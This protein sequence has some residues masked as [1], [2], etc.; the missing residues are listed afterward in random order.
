MACERVASDLGVRDDV[1][2]CRSPSDEALHGL[3]GRA[4]VVLYT[5]HDEHFGLVPVEAITAGRPVV[6]CASGGP[7][8][9]MGGE[10][11]GLDRLPDWLATLHQGL[12]MLHAANVVRAGLTD[13]LV[14]DVGRSF[15]VLSVWAAVSAMASSRDRRLRAG[16]RPNSGAGRPREPYWPSHSALRGTSATKICSMS[17]APP[18]VLPR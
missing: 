13:G 14:A 17:D 1:T 4:S 9:V 8:E 7:L 15:V 3:Y 6:A 18:A 5:P 2:F 11:G 10:A 12:P 16:R